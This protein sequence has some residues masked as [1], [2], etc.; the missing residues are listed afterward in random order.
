MDKAVRYREYFG[1][2]GGITISGGEPLL[3][4]EF[5]QAV[6]ALCHEKGINTCLDTSGIAF[7]PKR[8]ADWFEKL[9]QLLAVTDLVMLD[10][11]HVDPAS[12]RAL[13]GM[14]NEGI[15]AF[16]RHLAETYGLRSEKKSKFRRALELA[17]ES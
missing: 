2:E 15:L 14:D 5:V 3:Q 8:N 9:D 4:A 10:I 6:F 1:T 16:A 12:H 11:K 7:H 13:T 17:K